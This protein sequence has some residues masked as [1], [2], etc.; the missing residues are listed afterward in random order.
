MRHLFTITTT[1]Q[2]W[3][4]SVGGDVRLMGNLAPSNLIARQEKPR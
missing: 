3:Y 1:A 2:R 4:S